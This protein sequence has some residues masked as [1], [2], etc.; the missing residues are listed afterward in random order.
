M[1]AMILTVYSLKVDRGVISH[2]LPCK[3]GSKFLDPQ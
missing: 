2:N 3:I 1:A